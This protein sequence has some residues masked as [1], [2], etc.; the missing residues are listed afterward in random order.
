MFKK[1]LNM[2]TGIA[3]RIFNRK[4]LLQIFIANPSKTPA[5]LAFTLYKFISFRTRTLTKNDSR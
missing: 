5:C 4:F 3:A 2:N 1:M